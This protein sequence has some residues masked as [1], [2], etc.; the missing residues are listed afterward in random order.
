MIPGEHWLFS[1]CQSLC[2]DFLTK[3]F[4]LNM[5]M[6]VLNGRRLLLHLS[7]LE[8][9]KPSLIPL[10]KIWTVSQQAPCENSKQT[11]VAECSPE[12]CTHPFFFFPSPKNS[13]YYF[14]HQSRTIYDHSQTFLSLKNPPCK[15]K[16]MMNLSTWQREIFISSKYSTIAFHS[17]TSNLIHQWIINGGLS[18]N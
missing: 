2:S 18:P 15:R 8:T 7:D 10:Y 12:C 1:F 13:L 16:K 14:L 11:W 3:Y 6:L 4:L 5:V 9:E 17:Q